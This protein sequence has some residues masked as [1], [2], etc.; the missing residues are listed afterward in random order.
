[1]LKENFIPVTTRIKEASFGLPPT[2]YK[3]FDSVY[4]LIRR[5]KDT[6]EI[7][8]KEL[9]CRYI[10]ERIKLSYSTVNRALNKLQEKGFIKVIKSHI[11]GKGS[12]IQLTCCTG[13]TIEVKSCCTGENIPVAPEQQ[14][15]ENI[16]TKKTVVDRKRL[17]SLPV[18][19]IKNSDPSKKENS[20][21]TGSQILSENFNLAGEKEETF[22]HSAE[23]KNKEIEFKQ[24]GIGKKVFYSGVD[25]LQK[26]GCK[27]I[28]ETLLEIQNNIE[29][30]KRTI[31]NKS[32][33]F[34][35]LCR[36]IEFLQEAPAMQPPQENG[37]FKAPPAWLTE[38]EV[39]EEIKEDP[40]PKIDPAE[41]RRK[42]FVKKII[43]RHRAGK[44]KFVLSNSGEPQKIRSMHGDCFTYWKDS[45][46][47]VIYW[48]DLPEKLL[49]EK[50]FVG[51]EVLK[52]LV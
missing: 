13:D 38:E 21:E 35:S 24:E 50:L 37:G 18:S 44:V 52:T 16:Y 12:I 27:Y 36:K 25:A 31:K 23:F 11:K 20:Q 19:S 9:S 22:L 14:N 41:N 17:P 2:E 8:E 3:V 26:R 45:F 10:A 15:K 4:C 28:E 46:V 7:G 48:Q 47:K 40:T 34:L 33:Y 29:E 49:N 5:Y 6:R 32:G 1:M 43:E 30:R 39:R 42:E 51:E